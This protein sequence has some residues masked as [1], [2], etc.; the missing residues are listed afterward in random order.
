MRTCAVAGAGENINKVSSRDNGRTNIEDC[1]Y[2]YFKI[3]FKL[4]KN[5]HVEYLSA[6]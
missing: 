4:L 6:T 1:K 5:M 2:N 3:F